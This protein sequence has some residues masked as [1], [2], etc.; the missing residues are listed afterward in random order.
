MIRLS[1]LILFVISTPL[2]AQEDGDR[3]YIAGLLEDALGGP[4]RVVR[5]EGFRGALSATARIDRVTI[6][7]DDGIWLT[8]ED[9]AMSWNRAALLR[10]RIEI[11]QLEAGRI[12]LPRLPLPQ[13]QEPR[14]VEARGF[15]LPELPV[16]IN[17]DQ[18]AARQIEVGAPILGEAARMSLTASVSL[19][20]GELASNVRASRTDGQAGEFEIGADYVNQT[21]ELALNL[22]LTEEAGGIAARALNLPGLPSVQLNVEGRGPL[23]DFASDVRLATDNVERLVGRVTT[24]TGADPADRRFDVDVSGDVTAL[25]AP[26]YR[27]FFGDDLALVASGLLRGDGGFSLSQ[28]VLRTQSLSLGG[29]VELG[30]DTWPTLIDIEGRLDDPASDGVILPLN[31]PQISVAF[32]DFAI[33]FDAAQGDQWQARFDLAEPRRD[34]ITA[35]QLRLTANGTI[36]SNPTALG[37]VMAAIDLAVRDLLFDDPALSQAVGSDLTGQLAINYVEGRPVD[38]TGISLRGNGYDLTGDVTIAGLEE[39]FQTTFDLGLN[40]G[41]IATLSSL[42]G[43]DLSGSARVDVVGRA[44]LGGAFDVSVDGLGRNL[45][46]G[47]PQADALLTGDTELDVRVLRDGSGLTIERA[48]L[49]NPQ[50]RVAAL[51]RLTSNAGTLSYALGI[52][53]LGRVVAELPGPLNLDGNLARDG[54]TWRVRAA[55]TGP[56]SSTV[57]FQGR[58]LPSTVLTY[59]FQLPNIASLVAGFSGPLRLQG[60]VFD[61]DGR[62]GTDTALAG[63][64]GTTATLIGQL[65][66]AVDLGLSGQ[67]PLGLIGPFIRP[68]SLDGPIGFDLR[69][70]GPS[71]DQVSGVVRTNGAT[72]I[73]P[74][75]G[76]SIG[77]I[78]GEANLAGGQARVALTGNPPLGGTAQLSGTIGLS[79]GLPADLLNT[80]SAIVIE[81]PQLYR[82]TL[83]GETTARGPLQ[84]G[85]LIAGDMTIDLAEILVPSTSFGA[86]APIPKISHVGLPQAAE[87]TRG[88]AGLLR[89]E[90]GGGGEGIAYPIDV[91][92]RAPSRIFVRGRGLDAE[93]GGSLRLTGDTD[94]IVSVGAF[95]LIRGRLDILNRRFT[96]NQ[97]RLA[98]EGDFDPILDFVATTN[99]TDGTASVIVEGRSSSPR[100]RFEANP[101]V[102]EDEVLAQILFGRDIQQLSALQILQLANAIGTLAGREGAG[103][104]SGLRRGFALDDLDFETD[105]TGESSVR[106]GKYLTDNV[107]TDVTV[108]QEGTTDFSINIDVTSSITARGRASA[109]GD[110]ALGIFFERDY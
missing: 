108:G 84:G 82:V 72:L 56:F 74:N 58:L 8:I 46:I 52:P 80:L 71:L 89:S 92:V 86:L 107:Y 25:F 43:Q 83:S 9:A 90:N 78:S 45:T 10:G 76:I 67:A 13:E 39:A 18:L 22:S 53:D 32:G 110:T 3:G 64:G 27:P 106:L 14:S 26:D 105:D 109:D 7:D 34:D 6:A 37:S 99:T 68:R 70:R 93:L 30:P 97:G 87:I 12:A 61:E 65:S 57:E 29:R 62:L 81:D 60:K 51:G 4:G 38:V 40:A 49:E 1:L 91:L 28:M 69:A 85:A 104:L 35:G 5:I 19:E 102:P 50:A 36:D 98:L 59:D 11:S 42:L 88:R 96:L 21:E 95:D 41:D 23:S 54:D 94:N 77:N 75:E 24:G 16:A 79:P 20:G 73:L 101:S 33:A 55:G 66:P 15:S 47:I 103:L 2:L 31:G 44:D 48:I 17:I 100:I 63:P